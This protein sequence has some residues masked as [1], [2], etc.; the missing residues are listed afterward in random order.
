MVV[1][2]CWQRPQ[3]LKCHLSP[4]SAQ[5]AGAQQLHALSEATDVVNQWP[6]SWRPM[7][8]GQQALAVGGVKTPVWI[9]ADEM[10]G[11][12][13]CGDGKARSDNDGSGSELMGRSDFPAGADQAVASVKQS[14]T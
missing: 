10:G 14:V 6:G 2:R 12:P 8:A 4:G 1:G 5:L 7:A 3:S 11:K 13:P 9:E